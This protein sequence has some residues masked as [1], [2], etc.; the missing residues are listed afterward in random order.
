MSTDRKARATITV[1]LD[2]DGLESWQEE[3]VL[4]RAHAAARDAVVRTCM[5][6]VGYFHPREGDLATWKVRSAKTLENAQGG[7]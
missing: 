7:A 1:D 3:E 2:L 4:E 5:E 6:H